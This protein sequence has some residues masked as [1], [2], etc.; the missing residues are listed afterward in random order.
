M[1][2]FTFQIGMLDKDTQIIV[3]TIAAQASRTILRDFNKLR[4]NLNEQYRKRTN[5]EGLEG[6][7]LVIN[8]EIDKEIEKNG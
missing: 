7:R 6:L 8:R 5:I 2:K 4:Y 3:T 1:A